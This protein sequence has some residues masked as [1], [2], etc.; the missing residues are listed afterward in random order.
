M[1]LVPTLGRLLGACEHRVMDVVWKSD[2]SVT[3][4][5]VVDALPDPALAYTTVMTV[6]QRLV[7]K[8]LLIRDGEGQSYRYRAR[9]TPEEFYR[10]M[11]GKFL[12]HVREEFGDV[13]IAC[14]VEEAG[15]TDR[16]KLRKLLRRLRQR[17]AS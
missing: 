17:P 1:R 14:F 15:K 9:Y 16:R 11:A 5:R 4:R 8:G 12:R 10:T 2:G 13:A 3:V 6:M 7:E